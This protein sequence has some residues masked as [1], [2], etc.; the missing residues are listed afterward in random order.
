MT[1]VDVTADM[2]INIA[3]TKVKEKLSIADATV[4][5][6]ALELKTDAFLTYDKDFVKVKSM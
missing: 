2:A 6:S 4:L 1:I 3:E 5:I